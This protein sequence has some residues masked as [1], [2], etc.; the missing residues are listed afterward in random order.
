MSSRHRPLF[1][2]RMIYAFSRERAVPGSAVSWH[3]SK[4]HRTRTPTQL[5]L[6]FRRREARFLARGCR[7][8]PVTPP[9]TSPSPTS[10]HRH[11]SAVHPPTGNPD[12]PPAHGAGETAFPTRGPWHLGR[13]SRPVG[14]VAM[15]ESPWITVPVWR[16][17]PGLRQQP[18]AGLQLHYRIVRRRAV[19]LG[20][21][22]AWLPCRPGTWGFTGTQGAGPPGRAG[23]HS[24]PELV[25]RA[26]PSAGG[27]GAARGP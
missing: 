19:L 16:P 21:G 4:H 17:A 2:R 3:R 23:R 15:H 10:I 20:T 18:A 11:R 24:R 1:V 25:D 12:P 26:H 27:T 8:T 14:I 9:P 22:A 5:H 7:K 13:W 6:G